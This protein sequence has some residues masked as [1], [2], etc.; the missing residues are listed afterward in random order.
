MPFRGA[1]KLVECGDG[2]EKRLPTEVGACHDNGI[3]CSALGEGERR[4]E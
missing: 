3:C 2:G 1:C 4:L